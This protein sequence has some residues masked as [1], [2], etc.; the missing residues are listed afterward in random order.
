MHLFHKALSRIFGGPPPE[1]LRFMTKASSADPGDR[2]VVCKVRAV[3]A[4]FQAERDK[5]DDV[6]EWPVACPVKHG[7]VVA[8]VMAFH[9]SGHGRRSAASQAFYGWLRILWVRFR[10]SCE[11]TGLSRI[12]AEERLPT[13]RPTEPIPGWRDSTALS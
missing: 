7:G 9:N 8:Q 13:A 4:L 12:A 3:L 2:I 1:K 11:V 10:S 6:G 5:R